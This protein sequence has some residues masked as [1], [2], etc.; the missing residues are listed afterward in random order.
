MQHTQLIYQRVSLT[1]KC[2][3]EK[4]GFGHVKWGLPPCLLRPGHSSGDSGPNK[5]K[6]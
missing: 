4:Q 6:H 1:P 2:Q 3:W 5:A